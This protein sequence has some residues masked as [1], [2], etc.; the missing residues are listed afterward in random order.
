MI[1]ILS[2]NEIRKAIEQYVS[3]NVS[4]GKLKELN[5]KK[6]GKIEAV[7]ELTNKNLDTNTQGENK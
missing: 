1:L 5:C 7:I 3:I 6:G 4:N 2:D